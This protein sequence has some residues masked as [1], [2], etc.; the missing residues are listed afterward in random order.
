MERTPSQRGKLARRKGAQAERDLAK[1]FAAVMPGAAVRR[2]VQSRLGGDAADIECPHLWIESKH[3]KAPSPRAALE[4]AERDTD[5][6][7][8][9]AVIRYDGQAP[10]VCIRLD[11]FLPLWGEV[12]AAREARGSE[13]EPA[14]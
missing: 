12:F 5:G 7:T 3:G 13:T 11:Q 2:G 1:Q 6:R 4:Q 10:F 8:P 9:I 14:A